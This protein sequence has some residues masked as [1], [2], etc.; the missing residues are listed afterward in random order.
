MD[1]PAEGQ[2]ALREENQHGTIYRDHQLRINAIAGQVEIF[3][4]KSTSCS[5]TSQIARA[6]TVS[7][8]VKCFCSACITP[9]TLFDSKILTGL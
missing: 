4:E 2:S 6:G 8:T 9:E 5:L 3:P 7:V 1:D